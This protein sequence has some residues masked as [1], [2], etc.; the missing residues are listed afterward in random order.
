MSAET[1][2]NKS[3]EF[4]PEVTDWTG[5]VRGMFANRTNL[6]Y[7]EET[8]PLFDDK[9]RNYT[10][11]SLRAETEY[12]FYNR[13]SLVGFKHLREMLQRWVDRMPPDK[14]KSIASRIRHGG[15]GSPVEQQNFDGAF[16]ELF[17]HEFLNGT[18]GHTVVEPRIGRLT[19]DFGVTE[20]GKDG[21]KINYM[22]E[23]TDVNVQRGT[24]LDSNWNEKRALDILDEIET[25]DFRLFVETQG[26][27][28]SMPR[29]R[30]L[31]R[32]F[33]ELVRSANYDEVRAKSELYGFFDATLPATAF[34]HGN[35]SVAG[36]LIPVPPERRP[37][38][39]RFIGAGPTKVGG[40]NDIAKPK[41]RLYDKAK[42]YREVDNLIIA[43]SADWWLERIAEILFGSLAYQISVPNDPTYAGP[44]PPGRSIQQPDGFWFNTRGPL[45]EN[46]IGVVAFYGLHAHCVD[47]ANAVFYANPY[48]RKPMPSWTREITHAEYLDGKVEI[49]EGLPP[50]FFAKDHEPWQGDWE[51]ERQQGAAN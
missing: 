16:F 9:H 39:G 38:K 49:V 42:R 3:L 45:N 7:Q 18:G 28:A 43:I 2:D 11:P 26:T 46:V 25:P 29:K 40:V 15:F 8:V 34:Q 30:D 32:P 10:G 4:I 27:L 47:K 13:S 12:S 23:A 31:K 37:R 41:D 21:T 1:S 19:P 33:E 44:L 35:W 48:T 36:Q 14:Q 17:L 20:T 22:V 51:F 5:A 24:D 6:P 50:C